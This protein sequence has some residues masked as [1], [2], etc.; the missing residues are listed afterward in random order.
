M[1]TTYVADVEVGDETERQASNTE[2]GEWWA[3]PMFL[4]PSVL[5]KLPWRKER[6]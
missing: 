1:T 5:V 3:T 6:R 2:T 4:V